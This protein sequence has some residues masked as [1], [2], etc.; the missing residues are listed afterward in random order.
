M[1]IQDYHRLNPI[2]LAATAFC[3]LSELPFHFKV[4][5]G[6]EETAIEFITSMNEERITAYHPPINRD[7]KKRG[8]VPDILD[9]DHKII[10]EYEEETGPRRNGA[11][12]ARKGH[13]HEGDPDT[14]KDENRNNL[15]SQAGFRVLRI[16]ES[17]YTHSAIWKRNLFQFLI[18]CSKEIMPGIK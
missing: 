7:W 10:I 13:G 16:W 5:S 11:Y 4:D 17:H 2:Y 8:K 3:K 14:R 15:Y 6:N 12:L 9:W 1:G 18:D